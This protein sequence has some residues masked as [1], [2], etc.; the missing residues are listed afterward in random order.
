MTKIVYIAHPIGGDVENNV[1]RV[2]EVLREIHLS[3]MD[4]IPLAPYVVALNYLDDEN[5]KEKMMGMIAN[6]K[7]FEKK[8]IDEIWLAGPKI[9]AGMKQEVEEGL[10]RG[11][12][13][14]CYNPHLEKE[15]EIVLGESKSHLIGWV[16]K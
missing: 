16:K 5:P 11:I 1:K 14:K 8:M 9:S 12:P 7:F 15:L 13:I 4:V 10:K 2:C 6:K 3:E